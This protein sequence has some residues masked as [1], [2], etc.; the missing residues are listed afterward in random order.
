VVFAAAKPTLAP[1]KKQRPPADTAVRICD[2]HVLGK[3][4]D[5]PR[6]DLAGAMAVQGPLGSL[7]DGPAERERQDP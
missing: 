3:E 7:I 2:S 4:H 6:A 1:T 5:Y